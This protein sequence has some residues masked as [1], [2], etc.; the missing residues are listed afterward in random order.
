MNSWLNNHLALNS[1]W[2]RKHTLCLQSFGEAAI[3]YQ[4]GFSQGNRYNS[5]LNIKLDVFMIFN[6]LGHGAWE[7]ANEVHRNWIAVFLINTEP[8][9]TKQFH[10]S[11]HIPWGDLK[12]NKQTKHQKLKTK[13]NKT[14]HVWKMKDGPEQLVWTLLVIFC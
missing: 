10:H 11:S 6:W 2:H 14:R 13:Q 4:S 1:R 8:E 7:G 9:I 5:Q 12:T 3:Q